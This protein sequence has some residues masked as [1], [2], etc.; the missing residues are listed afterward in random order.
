MVESRRTGRNK[1]RTLAGSSAL[2][3]GLVM[4][5]GAVDVGAL[6]GV[7][8]TQ[9]EPVAATDAHTSVGDA[10]GASPSVSGDGRYVVFHGAPAAETD[11]RTATV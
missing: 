3:A 10:V 6:P 7:A 2:F 8:L 9:A 11:T 1:R 5:A 4:S